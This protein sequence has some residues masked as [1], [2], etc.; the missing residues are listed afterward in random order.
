MN[1]NRLST[2]KRVLR[3]DQPRFNVRWVIIEVDRIW[4]EAKHR[5]FCEISERWC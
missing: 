1:D 5:L 3:P 4:I 2:P